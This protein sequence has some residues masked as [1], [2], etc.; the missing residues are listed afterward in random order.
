MKTTNMSIR[1]LEDIINAGKEYKKELKCFEKWYSK[2]FPDIDKSVLK[3]NDK[4]DYINDNTFL[5]FTG[6][7]GC[8]HFLK[9]QGE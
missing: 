3:K 6:W 7:R 1:E 2:Q 9:Q 8:C 4:L 5:M